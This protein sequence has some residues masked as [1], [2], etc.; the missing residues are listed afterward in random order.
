[1]STIEG[2]I[3]GYCGVA[4]LVAGTSV[5][6]LA[7]SPPPSMLRC[8][9]MQAEGGPETYPNILI[10]SARKGLI[11][12]WDAMEIVGKEITGKGERKVSVIDWALARY[13]PFPTACLPRVPPGQ[14]PWPTNPLLAPRIDP[15]SPIRLNPVPVRPTESSSPSRIE[16]LSVPRFDPLSQNR[17]NLF[18]P[19]RSE[20]P[21]M[22]PRQD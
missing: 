9:K 14:R 3:L 1:M 12:P 13:E 17:P 6:Q 15:S 5:V 19:A 22:P 10:H 16:P 2:I 8:L 21:Q 11:W 7:T 18:P 20:L 4:I